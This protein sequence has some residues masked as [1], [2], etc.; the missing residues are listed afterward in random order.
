[1]WSETD[2]LSAFARFQLSADPIDWVTYLTQSKR[3]S[4]GRLVLMDSSVQMQSPRSLPQVSIGP[5]PMRVVC[6]GGAGV[7]SQAEKMRV[8]IGCV[9]GMRGMVIEMGG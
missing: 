8:S 6:E 4:A 1:M 2:D 3:R 7:R 5:K 9:G